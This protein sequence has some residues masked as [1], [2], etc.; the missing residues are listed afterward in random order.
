MNN[1]NLIQIILIIIIV[2][3]IVFLAQKI[4][5]MGVLRHESKSSETI[6]SGIP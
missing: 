1:I 6:E 5:K 4:E 3:G 2:F